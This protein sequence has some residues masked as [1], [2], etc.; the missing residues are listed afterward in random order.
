[1]TQAVSEVQQAAE[2]LS[3]AIQGVHFVSKQQDME[4]S[5]TMRIVHRAALL[6]HF[7]CLDVS[8]MTRA[9]KAKRMR[10]VVRSAFNVT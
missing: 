7:S 2:Q 1:M 3:K 10:R 9:F 6:S 5:L 8:R 4:N